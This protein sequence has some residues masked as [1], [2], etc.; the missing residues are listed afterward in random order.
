MHT[1][2]HIH[3]HIYVSSVAILAQGMSTSVETVDDLVS[4]YRY[5]FK[6]CLCLFERHDRDEVLLL[7]N[8][9]RI[10]SREDAFRAIQA[11]ITEP[12]ALAYQSDGWGTFIRDVRHLKVCSDYSSF[13]VSQR[14]RFRHEFLNQHADCSAKRRK[15][16]C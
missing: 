10:F 15:A 11:H 1:Y 14:G 3:T 5:H 12:I 9:L 7:A 8:A 4:R 6:T 16:H 13:K 2:M